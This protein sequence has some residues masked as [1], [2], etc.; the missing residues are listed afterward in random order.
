MMNLLL[1]LEK[2]IIVF[3]NFIIINRYEFNFSNRKI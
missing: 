3:Y 2:N 1:E